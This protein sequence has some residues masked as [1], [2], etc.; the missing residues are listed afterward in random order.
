MVGVSK[1]TKLFFRTDVPSVTC[2]KTLLSSHLVD[3]EHAPLLQIRFGAQKVGVLC[4]V[5]WLLKVDVDA[6][7]GP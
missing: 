3:A 7:G 6:V 4:V 1:E 2:I 5:H